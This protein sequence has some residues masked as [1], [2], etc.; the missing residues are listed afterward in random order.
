MKKKLNF[1]KFKKWGEIADFLGFS[2]GHICF[3]SV[4]GCRLLAWAA[5][6]KGARKKR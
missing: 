1:L 5:W 3:W 4:N 2:F 6:V